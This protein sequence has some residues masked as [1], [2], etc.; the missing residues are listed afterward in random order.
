MRTPIFEQRSTLGVANVIW[1][2]VW[3]HVHVHFLTATVKPH[4]VGKWTLDQWKALYFVNVK[5]KLATPKP[6]NMNMNMD[7]RSRSFL[8][9]HSWCCHHK[10]NFR[11]HPTS[12]VHKTHHTPQYTHH[13]PTITLHTPQ[14]IASAAAFAEE[15]LSKISAVKTNDREFDDWNVYGWIQDNAAEL[16]TQVA[17]ADGLLERL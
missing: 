14:M 5:N 3:I 8:S 17:I 13:T 12:A 1:E 10:H 9:E 6:R 16:H 15:R 2:W 4:M 11:P 7:S